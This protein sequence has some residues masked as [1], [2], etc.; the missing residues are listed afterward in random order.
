[1]F[2]VLRVHYVRSADS[3]DLLHAMIPTDNSITLTTQGK[4]SNRRN[5]ILNMAIT[6]L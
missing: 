1:M 4:I 6:A 5:N 2:D 3:V